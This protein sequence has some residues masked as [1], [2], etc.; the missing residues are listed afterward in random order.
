MRLSAEKMKAKL[1]RERGTPYSLPPWKSWSP[2]PDD[3]TIKKGERVRVEMRLMELTDEELKDAWEFWSD[4]PFK[5]LKLTKHNLIFEYEAAENWG[6]TVG[7]FERKWEKS[8]K[9]VD[10]EVFKVGLNHEVIACSGIG[11]ATLLGVGYSLSR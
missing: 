3:Y 4:F 11:V 7:E 8:E 1:T 6:G 2:F 9:V 5:Y 10:V